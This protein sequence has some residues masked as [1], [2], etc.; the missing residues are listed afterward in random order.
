MTSISGA[1]YEAG[2][3]NIP[4]QKVYNTKESKRTL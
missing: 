1:G 2:G 3:E 4:G